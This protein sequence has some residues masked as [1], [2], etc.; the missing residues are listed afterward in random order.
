[1]SALESAKW[2]RPP[3]RPTKFSWRAADS[4]DAQAVHAFVWPPEA[5]ARVNMLI[6][7]GKSREDATRAVSATLKRE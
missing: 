1:M 3:G 2:R 7:A 4:A 5:I 6:K